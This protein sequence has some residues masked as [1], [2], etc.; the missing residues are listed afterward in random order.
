MK[1]TEKLSRM[2]IFIASALVVGGLAFVSPSFN[3]DSDRDGVADVTEINDLG[4]DPSK[5]D[6]F[7][8]PLIAKS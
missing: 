3:V 8:K 2:R 7:H 4:T 6:T 1:R 5:A